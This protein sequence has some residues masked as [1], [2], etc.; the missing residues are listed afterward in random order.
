MQ[1]NR[2]TMR[3]KMK[4]KLLKTALR[5]IPLVVIS[6]AVGIRLYIWNAKTLVGNAMPMP[7][8]WGASVVLSGSMEPELSVDDLVIVRSCDSYKV[9]DV[10]VYQDGSMAVIHRIISIDGDEVITQGDANNTADD[11]IKLKDIKGK[12]VGSIPKIGA[13]VRFFQSPA[14]FILLIIA[15]VAVFELP[16]RRERQRAA[17]EQ[18]RIKEE[19]RRLK[20][21]QDPEQ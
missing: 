3:K 4:H 18:E 13:L 14:G 7:F 10:V 16:Y 15:A 21:E 12:S 5:V 8:G 1:T 19:I 2:E 11:S 6:L 17:D 9:G 20:G